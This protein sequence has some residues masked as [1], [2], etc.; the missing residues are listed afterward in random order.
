MSVTAQRLSDQVRAIQRRHLLDEAQLERLRLALPQINTIRSLPQQTVQTNIQE[1]LQD[2]VDLA[3]S[4]DQN[5]ELLRSA[6]E[7]AILMYR[8]K[9]LHLRPKLP[10]LPIHRRNMALVGALDQILGEY[11]ITSEDLSD[12]HCNLFISGKAYIN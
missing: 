1:K 8:F 11:L 9:P 10:R 5:D 2:G 7:D 4:T 6:L 12:T 3:V